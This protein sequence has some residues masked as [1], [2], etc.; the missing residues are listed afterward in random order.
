MKYILDAACLRSKKEAHEYLKEVLNLPDY[1]GNNLDALYDCITD[2]DR[3][4]IE[5]VNLNDEIA[6]TYFKR[7]LRILD[8]AHAHIKIIEKVLDK[9]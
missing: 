6:E 5:I 8:I 9:E 4:E 3:P 7:V 1:Y 2:M